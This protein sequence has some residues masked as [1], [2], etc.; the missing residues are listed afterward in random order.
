M[1]SISYRRWRTVRTAALDEIAN[2]HAAVGGTERGRRYTTQQVN[3]AYAMLLASQLQGFCRDLHTECV[4]FIVGVIAPPAAL[5]RL[6]KAEFHRGRQLDRGNAQ[7]S[8]L[9]AD[10]SRFGIDLWN[11]LAS[12]TARSV[13]WKGELDLLNEWRNAIAHQDFTSPRLS[14]IM[15]L[16]LNQVRQWRT[17]CSGLAR[18]MD[19][20][21]RLH[22]QIVTGASPW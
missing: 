11:E 16:R 1:S 15:N 12:R 2:A 18:A 20:L 9:G 14:G 19:Q 10:F 22:L 5:R 4:D 21:M 13:Q 6:V 8:S 3:R 7:S 17:S